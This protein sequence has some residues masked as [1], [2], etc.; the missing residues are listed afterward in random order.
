MSRSN[1]AR[2]P[3]LLSQSSKARELQALKPRALEPM[4]CNKGSPLN[5]KT[6]NCS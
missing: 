6:T 5:E 2:A 4:L 3:Q 1:E